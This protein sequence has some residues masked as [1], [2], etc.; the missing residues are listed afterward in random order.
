MDVLVLDA[1]PQGSCL[2]WKGLADDR[3]MDS[4]D[5]RKVDDNFHQLFPDIATPF[6]RVLIDCPPGTAS[7]ERNPDT[8]RQRSALFVADL[9]VVPTRQGINDIWE[10]Q[11]TLDLVHEFQNARSELK[12]RLLL[13]QIRS[14]TRLSEKSREALQGLDASIFETSLGLRIAFE[15]FP[16]SGVG[17]TRFEP[18]GKAAQEVQSLVDEI[19]SL[20]SDV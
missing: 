5:V 2:R 11:T 13:N 4:P 20:N 10:V 15:E 17:V 6:D 7:R 19:D 16:A 8:P 9:V 18:S 14:R 12:S 1:D 3:G